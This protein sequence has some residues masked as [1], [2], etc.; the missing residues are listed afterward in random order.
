[1]EGVSVQTFERGGRGL[2]ANKEISAG[3]ALIALPKHC[4][5]TYDN[6]SDPRLLHHIR[7]VPD[8][9]WG[10]KLALQL[11]NQRV[12][13][14]QSPFGR[15]IAALPRA[16]HGLPMFFDGN[17]VQSL[18]Y[19]PVIEQ[20]KKRCRWLIEF[21]ASNS[22]LSDAFDGVDIDAN[23]LGWAF[24]VVTSRA[25]R[26][27]GPHHPAAMLPLIDMANHSFKPNATVIPLAS[28]PSTLI[29]RASEPI[30]AG[31]EIV[32]SYGNL[33]N[34]FFLMDYGFVVP[35]NPFETVSLQFDVGLVEAAK[36]ISS[37][38]YCSSIGDGTSG[39]RDMFSSLAEWKQRPLAALGL[40]KDTEVHIK[41]SL[42]PVDS[43]LLAALRV[44]CA[45]SPE[46]VKYQDP[47]SL[48]VWDRPLSQNNEMM[49]LRT[50]RGLCAI[51]LARFSTTLEED[52]ELLKVISDHNSMLAVLFRME[53]KKVLKEALQEIHVR[54]G[55]VAKHSNQSTKPGK[56]IV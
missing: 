38:T 54:L 30:S 48:G 35:D 39:A 28:K 43:R 50:L 5:L 36:A 15:Y 41:R 44:M 13:G 51:V 3:D 27:R 11:L 6:S 40:L 16:I 2:A 1:M 17:T 42:Q 12:R 45:E 14:D 37:S 55:Q 10:A 26:T 19:P 18:E 8:E 29:L 47:E 22:S 9:L 33:Q 52:C 46:D 21:T 53:K 31:S 34:D 20:V 7:K 25:F 49:A 32:L 23:A 4:H 56:G 24:G